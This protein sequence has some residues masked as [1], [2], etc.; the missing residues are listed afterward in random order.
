[1]SE[2]RSR[3][4]RC[5]RCERP[6][7]ACWCGFVRPTSCRHRIVVLQHPREAKQT[8]GTARILREVLPQ[9]ELHVGA[10]FTADEAARLLADPRPP[11]LLYP[12]PLAEVLHPESASEPRTLI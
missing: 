3:R 12:G 8:F 7:V 6:L 1:M 5:A 11:L 10:R 4:P 2:E 9:T